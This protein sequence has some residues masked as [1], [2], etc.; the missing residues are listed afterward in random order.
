MTVD[1]AARDAARRRAGFACEFCGVSETDAGGELT[2]DHFQPRSRGGR[3]DLDNLLY[4]CSRCNQYKQ[5]YWPEQASD[6]M[7][8]NPRRDSRAEHFLELEDGTL[9]PLSPTAAFTIRRIR[10]NRPALV[11]HRLAKRRQTEALAML[12]QYHSLADLL[13]RLLTEQAGLL[14][15]Q[16]RL[17]EAQ[18]GLLRLLLN[19][20]PVAP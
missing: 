13:E 5:S 17:L 12:R 10:L 3:D 9:Y 16:Q 6:P 19:N 8:W 14:D 4:C 20:P 2:I 18:R 15:E 1:P 7:L 11:T